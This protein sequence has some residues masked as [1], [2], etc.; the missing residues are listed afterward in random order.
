[1]AE[2]S[3]DEEMF[4]SPCV[5]KKKTILEKEANKIDPHDR[6]AERPK[7]THVPIPT[8]QRSANGPES[9]SVEAFNTI[10]GLYMQGEVSD[11]NFHEAI[12]NQIKQFLMQKLQAHLKKKM[13]KALLNSMRRAENTPVLKNETFKSS[14]LGAYMG[15]I[16]VEGSNV[17][18]HISGQKQ[19]EYKIRRRVLDQERHGHAMVLEAIKKKKIK[20]LKRPKP[21]PDSRLD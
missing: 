3:E 1:M 7:V 21:K 9:V 20:N 2:E 6:F 15:S 14:K 17:Y 11:E 10:P 19:I 12:E 18:K 16:K 5:R 4:I 13:A 8:K